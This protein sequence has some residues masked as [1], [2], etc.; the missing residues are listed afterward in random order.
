MT[1]KS[2]KKAD[3][4]Y[5]KELA[6][7]GNPIPSRDYILQIIR[8][9]NAPMSREEILTAL[10]IKSDEQ[11]EAMRRRLRAME[12][13][14]QLVFTKRKRYAL[15][16]K[17]DLFKGMVI[18]HREGYGFLQVEGKK[19]D[20][21]I[22]NHQMQ[23]VMH[24]DFVLAQPAGV[25]RRGRREVRI[26]RVLES[27]KKQIVG[28]FFLENGFSYVVPDDSR[29]G[30]DILVPN[31]HRNGAR[32]GQVVVVELQERSASFTQPVGI[33]TE[34]LGD[35]MA[36]GMEVEIALRNHDIPHQF[37]SAVEKYIKKFTEEVPE[38]AKKGRVDLRNLPLVT[39]DGEDA[40]DFDDAVYC[41]KSGKG[42][43]L[44]VAI[45]DVSYY[46]RLRS[47]LDT[48]A[49]NRGNSV[50]FPNRVVPMLPEI[51]S[52]GLCSLNPQVDRLC[53][54]CEMH[55]SAK[56]KLTDYRFY[57]AVMNS[58]ARLTYT[59]VAAILDGDDELRTRYQ[60][61]LMT[62][63]AS[64][65]LE[66]PHVYLIGMEEGILPH[67]T[68]ID[69]D[70]VEEERRLAYVGITRAQQTL[71]FSLC[72]ERRQFG[73]LIRPEPSR[74]LAELPQDDVQWEKDKPKLTVEQKQQ[75]TS[76]QLD[77]LRAILKG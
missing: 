69:E 13:D 17:L 49:Y 14:G 54:V 70:N 68:S 22:P 45:A 36:K 24:G 66:F 15:P 30:R 53:M 57:E 18:G 12:N 6:K 50:Y 51:L 27:R 72:R 8:E 58:H 10:S 26:V 44:W 40:R 16:E 4:N 23:R 20:L 25:D 76:S 35:N 77:R 64:K 39:I 3:P 63:H 61:Q 9:N 74:F 67:Q 73:E 37:P 46:V 42:W 60:V 31:E 71:T 1:K 34:I 2:F 48:E 56:G 52:N 62:L 55:I 21:F 65:G 28:R 41:E 7:Y 38:E 29:I 32:M 47:A 5:Q 19:E 75:Q 11:Q 43:K 33:I 59:K